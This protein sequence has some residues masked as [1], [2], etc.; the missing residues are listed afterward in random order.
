M[1]IWKNTNNDKFDL[2]IMSHVLEH[3]ENPLQS[4]KYVYKECLSDGSALYL[5]VPNQ[6]YELRNKLSAKMAPMM[7]SFFFP[8]LV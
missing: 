6:D 7:H 5:D 3:L 4:I 2:V 8:D 1:I